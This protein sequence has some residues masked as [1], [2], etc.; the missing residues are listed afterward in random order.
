MESNN[1]LKAKT[2]ALVVA[3]GVGSPA[4][5]VRADELQD[6]KAQIELLQ[7]KVGELEMKQEAAEKSAAFL[8]LAPNLCFT[9]PLHNGAQ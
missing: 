9:R 6:L 3:I 2:L 1:A 4:T 5:A 8:I 7:K